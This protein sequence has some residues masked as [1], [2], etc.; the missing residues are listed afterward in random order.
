M[1]KYFLGNPHWLYLWPRQPSLAISLTQA[2]LVGYISGP[3][4]PRWLYLWPRQPSLAIS[5]TQATFAGYISD[6][7]NPL[8]LYLWPGQPSLAISLAQATLTGY[9]LLVI[10]KTSSIYPVLP[11]QCQHETFVEATQISA[12]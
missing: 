4:N 11:G 12:L 9:I 8:W 6:P 2:T 3:G 10:Y 1:I 7:G 5:L